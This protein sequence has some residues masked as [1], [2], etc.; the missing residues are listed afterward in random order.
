MVTTETTLVL[1]I[2]AERSETLDLLRRHSAELGQEFSALGYE[3]IDFQFDGQGD[4]PANPEDTRP[5]GLDISTVDQQGDSTK[6]LAA[7]VAGSG[8]DIRI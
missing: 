7:Y 2:S 8:V 4:R 1:T 5:V 6:A 3:T